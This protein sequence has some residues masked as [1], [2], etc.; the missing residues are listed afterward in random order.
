M[1]GG[2]ILVGIC[3]DDLGITCGIIEIFGKNRDFGVYV[4]RGSVE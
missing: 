2:L 1:K 4:C 3:V